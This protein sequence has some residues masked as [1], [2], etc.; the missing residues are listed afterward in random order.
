M[1]ALGRINTRNLGIMVA[2][3]EMRSPWPPSRRT[4]VV[5]AASVVKLLNVKLL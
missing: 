1:F 5:S 3:P 2:A 4:S